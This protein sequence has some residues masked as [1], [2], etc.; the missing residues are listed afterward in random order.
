MIGLLRLCASTSRFEWMRFGTNPQGRTFCISLAGDPR[1][2]THFMAEAKRLGLGISRFDFLDRT[3][4]QHTLGLSGGIN[5]RTK[6][7]GATAR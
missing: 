7:V 3:V 6:G 1:A 5:C 4:T 2:E